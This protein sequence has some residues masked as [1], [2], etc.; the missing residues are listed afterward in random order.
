V[1]LPK[2]ALQHPDVVALLSDTGD[3][4]PRLAIRRK[5]EGV[6]DRLRVLGE[7]TPPFDMT[8]LASLLGIRLSADPPARSQ[9]AEIGPGDDGRLE[10][11]LNR[12]RPEVRRRFSIGHEIGH[13]FFP[14][15]DQTVQ[16]RRPKKRDWSDPDDVVEHLCD[17]AA[18][19]LLFPLPWFADEVR[20]RARTAEALIALADDYKASREAMLR[21]YT[22]IHEE[23][24]AVAFLE[25][26]LK[27]TQAAAWDGVSAGEM[28]LGLDPREEVEDRKRLRVDYAIPSDPFRERHASQIPPD[29]SIDEKSVVYKAARARVGLDASEWLDLGSVR[30][31]FLVNAIPIPTPPEDR[32][33][34]GEFMV[35]VVLWPRDKGRKGRPAQAQPSMF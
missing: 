5:V 15:Y 28:L 4:D 2:S 17:C 26:K 25:W 6:I 23:A 10:L 3:T 14:G 31:N 24:V 30:G 34:R 16:T 18:S 33:P 1:A 20:R 22:E 7:P 11:R 9:D 29:K 13:T 12:E 27:P 21:R 19:E 32:G 35:A 8:L